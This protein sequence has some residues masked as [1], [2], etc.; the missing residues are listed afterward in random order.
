M[1]QPNHFPFDV[2][3][4]NN[5][6]I[7]HENVLAP[8]SRFWIYENEADALAQDA[9]KAKVK[10]LNGTWKFAHA[11]NPLQAID[12]F[13]SP[14]FD[15]SAWNE[16]QVP[17]IWQLQGHGIPQYSNIYYTFPVDPPNVPYEGNETGSYLLK[18]SV[19]DSWEDHQLRVRFDGVDSAFKLWINGSYI[20][21]S[22]GARNPSE[23]DVTSFV[24][25]GRENILAVQVYKWC[26]GTYIEDQDQWVSDRNF[27]LE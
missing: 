19:Q 8:R 10:S 26:N 17:G 6:E 1:V 11:S 24:Q 18:F 23:F 3:H 21:Y 15:S 4:W 9:S 16:I 22:E 2:P 20:G 5:L 25:F 13:Q 7:I 14:D 12:D 27:G